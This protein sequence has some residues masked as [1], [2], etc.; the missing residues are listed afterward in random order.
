M[1]PG[2]WRLVVIAFRYVY[3][4]SSLSP[5]RKYRSTLFFSS[6]LVWGFLPISFCDKVPGKSPHMKALT[7]N[8]SSCPSTSSVAL[9]NLVKHSRTVSPSFY[10][11]P[12]IECESPLYLC[13]CIKLVRN[14]YLSCAKLEMLPGR[15]VL[16][17][18]PALPSRVVGK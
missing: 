18:V 11:Q 1:W 8:P 3:F 2:L 7:I 16:N 10:L 13:N 14:K 6:A 4:A 5:C 12:I 9:M 15:S 17:H